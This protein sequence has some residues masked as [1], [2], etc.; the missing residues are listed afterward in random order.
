[1]NLQNRPVLANCE[2]HVQE[3][4]LHDCGDSLCPKNLSTK[5]LSNAIAVL[6]VSEDNAKEVDIE[7]A[8]K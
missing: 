2:L 7:K 4:Y 3:G 6:T 8:E 5:L 1:M